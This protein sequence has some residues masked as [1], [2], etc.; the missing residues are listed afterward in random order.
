[1]K[2]SLHRPGTPNGGNILTPTQDQ[3]MSSARLDSVPQYHESLTN[4]ALL[5]TV[6]SIADY[7]KPDLP[8]AGLLRSG[9]LLPAAYQ[10]PQGSRAVSAT[11]ANSSVRYAIDR[12]NRRI[13]AGLLSPA[14]ILPL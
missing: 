4:R 6:A 9:G 7:A 10:R 2:E 5:A 13:G 3:L 8:A 12:W 11:A 1:M 14:A